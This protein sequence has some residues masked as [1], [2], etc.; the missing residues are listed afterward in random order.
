M[1]GSTVDGLNEVN[2][3]HSIIQRVSQPWP[4]RIKK[5]LFTS[6]DC[7]EFESVHV[8]VPLGPELAEQSIYF[9]GAV[10]EQVGSSISHGE[11]W[12]T[13]RMSWW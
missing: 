2:T 10:D 3:R 4:I 8:V 12:I 11:C 9:A 13:A 6:L 1:D 7:G 5:A